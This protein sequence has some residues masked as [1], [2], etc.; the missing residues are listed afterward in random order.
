MALLQFMSSNEQDL[1]SADTVIFENPYFS[2]EVSEKIVWF[3]YALD[4]LCAT[5][6]SLSNYVIKM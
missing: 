1:A 6:V 2:N 5:I 3:F 4:S